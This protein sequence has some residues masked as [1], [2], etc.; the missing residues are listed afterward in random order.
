[1]KDMQDCEFTVQD[2]QLFML[3]TRNGKRTGNAA[4][5]VAVE[6]EREVR[7]SPGPPACLPACLPDQL[8]LSAY[9][10]QAA[11]NSALCSTTTVQG[12]T[13]GD[14]FTRGM[15]TDH[16]PRLPPQGLVTP[17]GAIMLVEPR[18]LDQLLHPQFEDEKAYK[19]DVL[20]TGLAASPGAA[21][22][23]LVFTADC[24][25]AWKAHG[26]HVIL[27]RWAADWQWPGCA[28]TVPVQPLDCESFSACS[29]SCVVSCCIDQTGLVCS[30]SGPVACA[31]AVARKLTWLCA[32]PLQAGDLPGGRGRHARRRGHHHR[33]RWH[34][35]TRR[36]GGPRLG[37]ALRVRLRGPGGE[38]HIDWLPCLPGCLPACLDWT[39]V[40]CVFCDRQ[41]VVCPSL[42]TNYTS[43]DMPPVPSHPARLTRRPRSC[44]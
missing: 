21:V 9:I 5:R 39:P 26:N 44:A 30:K 42:R 13:T 31:A 29:G 17:Q 3:Q 1:M 19:R 27:V 24:A 22:G 4:L 14:P 10:L 34:D 18:H 43:A 38:G 12:L 6:M 8:D 36:R 2:G 7:T 16:L 41:C 40:Y 33:P 11:A 37:Q 32:G 25:E 23:Q 35:L 20:A 15:C 28:C